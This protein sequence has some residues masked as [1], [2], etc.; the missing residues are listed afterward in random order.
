[1]SITTLLFFS[2][3]YND[4]IRRNLWTCRSGPP[5]PPPPPR[6]CNRHGCQQI[7]IPRGVSYQCACGPGYKLQADGKSCKKE[8]H[9]NVDVVFVVDT[10]RSVTPKSFRDSMNILRE[11]IRFIEQVNILQASNELCLMLSIKIHDD[12]LSFFSAN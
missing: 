3:F 6:P 4:K 12:L 8:C 1:M 11:F 2:Q 7:C 5:P 10:S 9:V